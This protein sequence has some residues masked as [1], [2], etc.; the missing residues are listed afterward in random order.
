V[1]ANSM[2][3]AYPRKVEE[4]REASQHL[5]CVNKKKKMIYKEKII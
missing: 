1:V 4:E 5:T 2:L 3:L